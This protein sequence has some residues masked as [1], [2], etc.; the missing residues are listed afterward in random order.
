[1]DKSRIY[2]DRFGVVLTIGA[3]VKV[4]HCVGRFGRTEVIVGRLKRINQLGNV[5]VEP[6]VPMPRRNGLPAGMWLYPG[7]VEDKLLA[8][9]AG[10]RNCVVLRGYSEEVDP[11]HAHAKFIEVL[12]QA[13]EQPVGDD[14]SPLRLVA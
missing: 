2:V 10:Y 8:K 5:D 11:D 1:M 13:G 9:T 14:A 7:F 4:Q 3:R 12:P 6:D